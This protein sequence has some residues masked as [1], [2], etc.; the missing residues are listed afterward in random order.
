MRQ[1]SMNMKMNREIERVAKKIVKIVAPENLGVVTTVFG[2][3]LVQ[4]FRNNSNSDREFVMLVQ[5]F[6]DYLR[7]ATTDE[8]TNK[9]TTVIEL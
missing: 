8:L 5:D 2:S 7:S 4:S 6:I 3:I 9:P 1:D